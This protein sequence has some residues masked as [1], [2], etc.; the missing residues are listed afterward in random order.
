MTENSQLSP[1]IREI[2]KQLLTSLEEID[3]R[4]PSLDDV[5]AQF[6]L[7]RKAVDR[8]IARLEALNLWG[9]DN[10][11]PSSELWNVAG[12]VLCRGWMQNQARTKPRGYSGDYEML[13]RMYQNRLCDDTLGRHFDRYFQEEA[14]PVAVR[15]RM[16]M[17]ADWIV[18]AAESHIGESPLHVAMVGSAFGLEI[19]DALVRLSP[20]QRQQVKLTLLDLDPAA[21]EFAR[22]QLESLVPACQLHA[23][24][25]NLFRLPQRSAI[26][27]PLQAADLLFCPGIFDYL[28]DEAAA[29]M[30]RCFYERLAPGGT[31]T[32]FQFAPTNTTRT[33]ME[34]L[35][36][37]YLLY[38]TPEEFR[39]VVLTAGIPPEGTTH[40]S[41]P[42]G[43]ALYVSARRA[44]LLA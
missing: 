41:E 20:A 29:A 9:R 15:N 36:N 31:M 3:S 32:V 12:H 33:Y 7:V 23:T 35:G 10:Q 19:R 8:C 14:A 17:M 18:A 42:L 44:S 43:V 11:I 30:L 22:S 6:D 1:Q 37:W 28:D 26:S 5:D 38:R 21:I 13:S 2:G 16:R 24:S 40:G 25:A 4:L 27:V 34:W 39:R